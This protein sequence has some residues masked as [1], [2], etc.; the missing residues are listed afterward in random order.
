MPRCQVT[1]A[2]L[3]MNYCRTYAPEKYPLVRRSLPRPANFSV[4]EHALSETEG[5][6]ILSQFLIERY[7]DRSSTLDF[8]EVKALHE[9][10]TSPSALLM[11][12]LYERLGKHEEAYP[13]IHPACEDVQLTSAGL[14]L[15]GDAE[16]SR[17]TRLASIAGSN[18]DMSQATDAAI[19]ARAFYD[20]ARAA[21]DDDVALLTSY[22]DTQALAPGGDPDV[23]GRLEVLLESSPGDSYLADVVATLW[24]EENA[25]H[26]LEIL[27]QAILDAE[28]VDAMNRLEAKRK[29]IEQGRGAPASGTEAAVHRGTS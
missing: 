15:C 14:K 13:W 17:A 5:R 8:V 11:G 3:R 26:S 22:G 20:K 16:L 27:K 12:A 10:R 2:N 29:L 28:S 1:T 21:G 18:G 25:D 19:A 24:L 23:R 4:T 9:S 6:F 7:P